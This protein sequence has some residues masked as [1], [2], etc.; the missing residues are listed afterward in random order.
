MGAAFESFEALAVPTHAPLY[1]IL[2]YL[3]VTY[4]D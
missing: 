3:S 1:F 4:P 2:Y